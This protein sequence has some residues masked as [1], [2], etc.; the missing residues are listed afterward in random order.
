MGLSQQAAADLL[1]ISKSSIELY[2]RG[3]RRDDGRPALIP[4]TVDLACKYL[5]QQVRLRRQLDMLES[6]K[7]TTRAEKGGVMVDTSAESAAEIRSWISDFDSALSETKK[8]HSPM[9]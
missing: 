2:E 9:I 5:E 1:G 4:I 8:W 7:M 3:T 6:G